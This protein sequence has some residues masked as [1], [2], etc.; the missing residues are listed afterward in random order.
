MTSDEIADTMARRLNQQQ[1]PVYAITQQDILKQ[2][3]RQLGNDA[4]TLTDQEI[5]LYRDEVQA[6][7]SHYIDERELYQLALQQFQIIRTL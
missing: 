3:A 7:F 1:E 2:L 5:T 4:L 6:V